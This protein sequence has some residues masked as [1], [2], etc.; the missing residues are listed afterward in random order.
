M[1]MTFASWVAIRFMLSFEAKPM[2]PREL[3]DWQLSL[4]MTRR[5]AAQALGH[6]LPTYLNW[7]K[8]RRRIPGA[9]IVLCRYISKYG[10]VL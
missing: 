3:E 10:R 2:T 1:T 8:G 7:L 4:V 6:S 9:V 5:E